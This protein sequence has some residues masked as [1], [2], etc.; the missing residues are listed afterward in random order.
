MFHCKRCGKCCKEIGREMWRQPD[1]REKIKN[2]L[3]DAL[4]KYKKTSR[5]ECLMLGYEGAKAVCILEKVFGVKP[6]LCS[7]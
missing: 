3:Y 5:G 6:K 7:M 2:D 1:I 4:V